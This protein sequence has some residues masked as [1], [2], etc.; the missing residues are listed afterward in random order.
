MPRVAL[1]RG[2]A[3]RRRCRG[4]PGAPSGGSG[5]GQ[6]EGERVAGAVGELPYTTLFRR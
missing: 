1:R 6:E 3:P 2:M 4:T 5:L